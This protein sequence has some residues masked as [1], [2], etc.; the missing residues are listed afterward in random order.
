MNATFDSICKYIDENTNIFTDVSKFIWENPELSLKEYKACEKYADVLQKGGFT[1]ERNICGI[2]TA[3]SGTFGS[4][5]P[6][7]GILGEYDALS[8]LSQKGAQVSLLRCGRR[9]D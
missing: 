8:G 7:I 6:I 9:Q 3:V 4:G 1:V 5:H 2:K